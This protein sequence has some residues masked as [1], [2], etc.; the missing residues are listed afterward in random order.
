MEMGVQLHGTATLHMGKRLPIA[1][2]I[3]GP[4]CLTN[5]LDVLAKRKNLFPTTNPAAQSLYFLT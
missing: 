1:S 3:K 5:G 4:A 2:W